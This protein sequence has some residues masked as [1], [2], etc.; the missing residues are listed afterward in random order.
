MSRGTDQATFYPETLAIPP[1]ASALISPLPG[2]L[3]TI[4]KYS[5]GGSLAITNVADAY[6]S[7]FATAQAYLFSAGEALSFD[8][9]GD[10]YLTATGA[11]AVCYLFRGRTSGTGN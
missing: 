10:F 2:Q 3:S 7:T 11:T 5:S 1:G 6:G 4:I 8:D 9:V